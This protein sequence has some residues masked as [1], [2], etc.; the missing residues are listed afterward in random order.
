MR[1]RGA[2]GWAAA[3]AAAALGIGCA[4]QPK[5]VEACVQI[6]S[7][8]NLHTYDGQ[9]HV[10]HVYFYALKSS[11][12]FRQ[13]DVR[14]LLAGTETP[15]GVVEGPLELIVAP[16]SVVEFREALDPET[17]E[18]GIVADYFRG[19][20]DPPGRRKGVVKATCG[21]FRTPKIRLTPTDLL[22]E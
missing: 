4:T 21:L 15:A 18:L 12:E 9:P 22:V 16:S 19:A 2:I 1:N 11:L 7:G 17:V 6:T 5:P 14:M 13:M 10:V 3:L 8:T 20:D